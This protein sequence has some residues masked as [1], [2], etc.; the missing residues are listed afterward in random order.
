MAILPSSAV[1][2]CCCTVIAAHALC[3]EILV[4]F[5]PVSERHSEQVGTTQVDGRLMHPITS[6]LASRKSK[7]PDFLSVLFGLA[8]VLELVNAVPYEPPSAA[9]EEAFLAEPCHI[10][11]RLYRDLF[12][13]EETAKATLAVCAHC[14]PFV[15]A[16]YWQRIF[17]FL[18]PVV[19][20]KVLI[21][22]SA[23]FPG[24]PSGMCMCLHVM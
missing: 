13:D 18:V 23:A 8:Q 17:Y 14:I 11:A 9:E 5:F 3:Q 2:A 6:H 1:G 20:L 21:M 7:H 4:L 15:I 16:F 22:Q 24:R 19:F 10:L 12:K